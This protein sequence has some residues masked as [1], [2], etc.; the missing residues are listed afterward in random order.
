MKF[1]KNFL[2]AQKR[3]MSSCNISAGPSCSACVDNPRPGGVK[4]LTKSERSSLIEPLMKKGWKQCGHVDGIN[5]RFEWRNFDD[6]FLF[7]ESVAKKAVAQN[8]HPEWTNVYNVVN[9]TLTTHECN[10]LS[11]QDV[12]LATEIEKSKAEV[13]SKTK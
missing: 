8:H 7:M 6:A 11:E 4:L 2:I 13:E 3:F 5:K 10:G 9:I 12:I 1:P